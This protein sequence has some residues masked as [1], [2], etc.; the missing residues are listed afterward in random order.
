MELNNFVENYSK[1]FGLYAFVHIMRN[2]CY[3]METMGNFMENSKLDIKF[4]FEEVLT[5]FLSSY[6]YRKSSNFEAK[7]KCYLYKKNMEPEHIIF[8]WELYKERVF[9]A[10][11]VLEEMSFPKLCVHVDEER[12]TIAAIAAREEDVITSSEGD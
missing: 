12:K 1:E 5:D 9:R 10:I 4:E 7:Q 6:V 11:S 8:A 2:V 3:D